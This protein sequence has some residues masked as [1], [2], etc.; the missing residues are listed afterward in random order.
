[1]KTFKAILSSLLTFSLLF[2]NAAFA[3]TPA[4]TLNFNELKNTS[5]QK[6]WFEM[7]PGS[8]SEDT[9]IVSNLS[10]DKTIT[11]TPNI[12]IADDY[13]PSIP[14]EWLN[15][16]FDEIEL[17]PLESKIVP[18]SVEIPS[19]ATPGQYGDILAVTLTKY[20]GQNTGGS[21]NIKIGI[22]KFIV[23]KVLPPEVPTI[24]NFN[25][26]GDD[27]HFALNEK[28]IATDVLKISNIS[29]DQKAIF[30]ISTS[31]AIVNDFPS[32]Y[33]EIP[34]EWLLIDTSNVEI[35]A[36]S[37]KEINFT[38][39]I[40]ENANPG[41]YISQLSVEPLGFDS[42]TAKSKKIFLQIITPPTPPEITIQGPEWDFELEP[43]GKK[44]E[45]I[46]LTNPN[47]EKNAEIEIFLE[48]TTGQPIPKEWISF[49]DNNF[50]MAAKEVKTV[51]F[52]LEIPGTAQEGEYK[53]KITVK[54]KNYKEIF[55]TSQNITIKVKIPAPIKTD[56][57]PKLLAQLK[58]CL[59]PKYKYG[60]ECAVKKKDDQ[61]DYLKKQLSRRFYTIDKQIVPPS[62]K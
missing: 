46:I 56:A 44:E 10:E 60:K 58:K 23:I 8:T 61:T 17:Q 33:L 42:A 47:L 35:P 37:S 36:N 12:M 55:K 18:F 27:W 11:L 32:P 20:S 4:F 28:E 26:A 62:R 30:K 48:S 51:K 40:P 49:Q 52:K 59:N 19:N 39:N 2:T 6:Y 15:I 54:V 50:F 21:I 22:G 9:F 43:N 57:D 38:L 14:S 45:S 34:K 53:S 1:M 5:G 29:P 7:K 41:Y 31:K 16:P 3:D 13:G 24:P 25:I